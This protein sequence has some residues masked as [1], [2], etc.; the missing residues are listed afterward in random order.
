[1]SGIIR[2]RYSE[3]CAPAS[4]LAARSLARAA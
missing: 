2:E 1:L 4:R 3:P